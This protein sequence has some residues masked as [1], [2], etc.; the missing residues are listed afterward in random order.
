MTTQ[1]ITLTKDQ[2][3]ALE[4][5]HNFLMDPIETVFVLRGYSGCGKSTLVR[6]L[7]DRLP[8][9]NKTSRLINPD[10][11]EYEVALTATTNKAAENLGNITGQG[12]VT[13]HSFLGLRV[14]TDYRTNTTTLIP[15]NSDQK[16]GYLLFIDEASY[17]DK[18]LLSLIFKKTLNCKIVFIGDPAQL[19]PVKATSTPVFDANFTGAALTTVVRQAEGNPIVDLSTKFRNTVNTG[20]FFSFTPDGHHVQYLQRDAFNEA[21]KTEFTRPDWRYQDSKILAWTNKCVIGYNNFVRNHVKGNP[22]FQVDDYAICNSFVTVGR[23]S[24]KTDQLVHIN[25]IEADSERYG[26]SGNMVCVD[27]IWVF[28]P[29]NLQEWNAGIKQMR[30]KDMFGAVSEMESQWIDLRAAYACTINKAQGSTFDRVFV[31]LDDIRRCN[32]GDQIARMLYVGVSRARTQV[33]LTG[34]LV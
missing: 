6:T 8:G 24:I 34:D 29:K 12:A 28:H 15:R 17:V 11:K 26:V 10:H 2:Q 5:F 19:T 16:A 14:Q 31:D 3:N 21:I 7:I 30:A 20:E 22:E 32:S 4:Y 18:Q 1:E 27:G 13:I 9:F 23:S 33:F 25:G